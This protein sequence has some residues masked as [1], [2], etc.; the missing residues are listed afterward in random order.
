MK[1]LLASFWVVFSI[2]SYSQTVK[3]LVVVNGCAIKPGH[4]IIEKIPA[5]QI[6]SVT[7]YRAADAVAKYGEFLGST[8]MVVIKTKL[9]IGKHFDIPVE[10]R[11]TYGD[12]KPA[13]VV[14]GK[15]VDHEMLDNLDAE[16]VGSIEVI[17]NGIELVEKYGPRALNGVIFVKSR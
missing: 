3:P 17:K 1:T 14:D 2:S 9:E 5:D 6:E 4:E 15:M 16:S 8:G 7:T 13:I 12:N 11:L 10:S